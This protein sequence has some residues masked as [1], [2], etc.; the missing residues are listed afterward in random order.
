LP[1]GIVGKFTDHKPL[2]MH[3]WKQLLASP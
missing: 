2:T 3:E 1:S